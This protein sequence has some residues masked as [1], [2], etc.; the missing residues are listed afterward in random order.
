MFEAMP[1]FGALMFGL[2]W[3]LIEP[4]KAKNM[5]ASSNLNLGDGC[6]AYIDSGQTKHFCQVCWL[7]LANSGLNE[8]SGGPVPCSRSGR[9]ARFLSEASAHWE[10]G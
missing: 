2:P 8:I 5:A 9:S 4:V 6:R 3:K 7:L 1:Q 10:P